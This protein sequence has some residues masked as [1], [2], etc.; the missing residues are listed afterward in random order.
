MTKGADAL[1][2]A[3]AD[4]PMVG[5]SGQRG[6]GVSNTTN[7]DIRSAVV[8]QTVQ[9]VYGQAS[10][11][12]INQLLRTYL[13]AHTTTATE[14]L[15]NYKALKALI[16]NPALVDDAVKRATAAQARLPGQ[17]SAGRRRF[18]QEAIDEAIARTMRTDALLSRLAAKGDCVAMVLR[19]G[20]DGPDQEFVLLS[21]L[22][23]ETQPL[24]S[25]A[26]KLDHVL[27]RAH[28]LEDRDRLMPLLDGFVADILQATTVVQDIFG[29]RTSLGE[30]LR[31]QV[32]VTIRDVGA[33]ALPRSGAHALNQLLV[34]DRLPQSKAVLLDRVRRQLKSS[35]PL[36]RGR[37][38]DE[39]ALFGALLDDLVTVDGVLG[40]PPMAE[41]LTVRFAR[42]LEQG[43][44]VGMLLAM[45]GMT[46]VLPSLLTKLQYL[47]AVASLEIGAN[48]ADTIETLVD[49]LLKRDPLIELALFKPFQPQA[50]SE[51]LVTLAA[52]FSDCGLP[53]DVGVRLSRGISHVVDDY[54]LRGRLFARLDKAEPSLGKRAQRYIEFARSGLVHQD[55][56]VPVLQQKALSLAKHP[57]FQKDVEAIAQSRHEEQRRTQQFDALAAQMALVAGGPSQSRKQTMV[58]G[59]SAGSGAAQWTTERPS[60]SFGL[61][62]AP[63]P[64][65]DVDGPC[66]NCFQAWNAS[67]SCPQ[68]GFDV[69]ELRQSPMHIAPG[70]VL[71]DRY[72][73][74]RLLG[75]GG[76]GATYVGWDE[77]LQ[78]R[79]ALKEYF[80][81]S[82]VSR[83]PGTSQV[84]PLSDTHRTTFT[85]GV[86]RFLDEARILAKLRQI[87]EIVEVL[88]F[89]Q[90]NG[91]AYFIMEL[92][93]GNTLQTVIQTR[94]GRLPFHNV[95]AVAFP[96]MKAVQAV[97]DMGLVHRDISP[98]NIFLTNSKDIK[99]LDFGA[100]RHSLGEA[101]GIL[102]VILKRGFAPPEQYATESRQGPWTDVYALCATMYAGLT[103]KTP[104][105]A[106]GRWETDSLVPPSHAGVDIPP[107]AEAVLLSGL[108]MRWQDR[109]QSM[110]T[111]Y[112]QFSRSLG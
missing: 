100:A 63:E 76:F 103:G 52:A 67:S 12:A 92:L 46:D 27:R 108:S 17:D 70:T 1:T 19:A 66:P 28:G 72:V 57:D 39:H 49:E 61:T 40:G 109:P 90:E 94:G 13:D 44:A 77:R 74:G 75:Q 55:G 3:M 112:Q 83:V 21:A 34:A 45:K 25:F 20:G 54:V 71:T 84:M 26:T 42:R 99:L 104:P 68:C 38:A 51:R 62:V 65:T 59:A 5:Q 93:E 101:T 4:I 105:D 8:C 36:T 11:T 24:R 73:V 82:L 89:F 10:R 15:H 58:E 37:S 30:T 43:G 106:S 23:R 33:A 9:D 78:V 97:H 86:D 48:N 64:T 35:Q 96:I 102:T 22:C 18:I 56:A 98:D 110:K 88:D 91:T 31:R 14:V 60:Q 85:E 81:S 87:K 6:M 7:A 53:Q 79:V 29:I 2:T 69:A 32:E 95:L 41:A 111:L 80:P 47:A 50:L 107:A 16:G